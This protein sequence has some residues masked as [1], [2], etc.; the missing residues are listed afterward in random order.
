MD[1]FFRKLRNALKPGGRV[2]ILDSNWTRYRGSRPREG[3]TLRTLNDGRQF[4]IYKRYFEGADFDR[5]SEVCE[6]DFTVQYDGKLYLGVT[7]RC[8]NEQDDTRV[9]LVDP[10]RTALRCSMYDIVQHGHASE[11]LALSG[12]HLEKR[13]SENN[14][15]LGLAYTLARDPYYYGDDPPLLLS[16]LDSGDPVGV[17]VRSPP[18]RIVLSIYDTEID[19]AVGGLVRHLQ[20]GKVRVPGV[21]GPEAE[22]RSFSSQWI[23][24]FPGCSAIPRKRLRYSR[25]VA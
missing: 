15:P 3:T 12:S 22:A 5:M 24:T 17:A 13:E 2:L 20:S 25:L 19:A 7:G 18:Y 10:V 4:E 9:L 1:L 23:R 8:V 11:L 16:I 6:M 21:V 14:L